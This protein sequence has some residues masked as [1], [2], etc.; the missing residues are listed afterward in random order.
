MF[1]WLNEE[2]KLGSLCAFTSFHYNE[3][4]MISSRRRK[5]TFCVSNNTPIFASREKFPRDAHVYTGSSVWARTPVLGSL[6]LCNWS[7]DTTSGELSRRERYDNIVY[8][9]NSLVFPCTQPHCSVCPRARPDYSLIDRPWRHRSLD[10]TKGRG[11]RGSSVGK[12]DVCVSHGLCVPDFRF[13]RVPCV[14][15]RKTDRCGG[16]NYA[17]G[18]FVKIHGARARE[19]NV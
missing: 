17:A 16:T 13:G 4:Q 14:W 9:V 19:I 12:P 11:T 8:R 5:K 15:R 6:S 2:S 3:R 10:R 7:D 18:G 1:I